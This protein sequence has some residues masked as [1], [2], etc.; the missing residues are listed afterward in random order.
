VTKRKRKPKKPNTTS[1][2]SP[3]ANTE[4]GTYT[5]EYEVTSEPILD[6]D[7]KR[8]PKKVQDAIERLHYESQRR[9]R[10]AIPE[11]LELIEKY[12]DVPVLYNYLGIAY[13]R[14]GQLEKA[15]ATVRENYQR[16]PDYLFARLNYA[17]I[18]LARGD[19]EKVAKILEHKFE[20]KLLYPKRKRFH[21]SEVINFMGLVGMYFLAIGKRDISEKYYGVLQQI[22]PD[23]PITRQLRRRLFPGLLKRLYLRLRD[24]L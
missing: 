8:L 24:R 17:E 9:P 11:L 22:G 20:L 2:P 4:N 14:S 23:Y 21:I 5:I 19:Y 18:C 15:E 1:S 3:L 6:R 16:N 13:S 7:Y 10:E 12:P